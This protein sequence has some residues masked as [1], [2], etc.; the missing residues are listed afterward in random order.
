MSILVLIPFHM[1]RFDGTGNERGSLMDRILMVCKRYLVTS[2]KCQDA[3]AFL[4]A[5]F[6]TRPGILLLD[7]INQCESVILNLWLG[8]LSMVRQDKS[9]GSTLLVSW[10][11]KLH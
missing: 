9:N 3:A 2:N 10:K 8:S 1:G 5:K 4:A 7:V 6:L 11:K